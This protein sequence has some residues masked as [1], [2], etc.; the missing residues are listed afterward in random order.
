MVLISKNVVEWTSNVKMGIQNYIHNNI[1]P[2]IKR[3]TQLF[4]STKGHAFSHCG[5]KEWM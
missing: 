1:K 3:V 2:C 4:L 5:N